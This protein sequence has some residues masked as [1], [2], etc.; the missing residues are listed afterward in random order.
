M[1][2]YLF[3]PSAFFPIRNEQI[4]GMKVTGL[5]AEEC[6]TLFDRYGLFLNRS[7]LGAIDV[8]GGAGT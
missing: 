3:I 1:E 6:P 8:G 2:V 7:R 5:T 4:S